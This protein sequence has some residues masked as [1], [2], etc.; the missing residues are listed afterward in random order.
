MKNIIFL[1]IFCIGNVPFIFSQKN[2]PVNTLKENAVGTKKYFLIKSNTGNVYHAKITRIDSNW[3]LMMDPDG[4]YHTVKTDQLMTVTKKAYNS[5]ISLGLG[6]GIPYGLFGFNGDFN[7]YNSLYFSIGLGS[8]Y[9][10]GP[11]YNVGCK[12][13]LRSGGYKWRP[14]VLVN[15]GVFGEIASD[16]QGS[17]P[18][19]RET[20]EG[21]T[22]GVGQQWIAGIKKSWGFDFDII[23]LLENSK[24]DNSM[25]EYKK[26]GYNFTFETD[27]SI[28]ISLGLRYIF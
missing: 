24:F 27:G 20:I 16:P 15:Y 21:F 12:Y 14:R 26:Q 18:K 22:I 13:Y 2:I 7:I 25:E 1:L 23:Y 19:I 6:I 5:P 3:T 8:G 11:W 9:A 17:L 4:K 28:K 10:V